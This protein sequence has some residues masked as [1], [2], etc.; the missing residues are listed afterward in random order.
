MQARE[1]DI[2]RSRKPK[3]FALVLLQLQFCVVLSLTLI[4]IFLGKRMLFHPL[5]VI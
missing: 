5:I 3:E 2:S 1:T 4:G